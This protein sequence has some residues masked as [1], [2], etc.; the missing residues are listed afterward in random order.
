M[1]ENTEF[2]LSRDCEA[3]Q[4]PSGQTT[5][6]PAGTQGVIT[7]SLGGS[8]TI[9]TYQGLA[10]IAERDLDALGLEKS[11]AQPTQKPA[12]TVNGEVSEEDVW[13]QLRQ[14][15][16]PEIPV[17]IVDL[18]LVYDCR[19]IKKDGGGT[20]VEV[21]M[22]LT[23]PG[24]GMGPAIAHDAQSKILSIDGVDEADVQL[25]WDPPWNQNMISEAGRMKLGM[26][27]GR[28]L[29]VILNEA[30]NLWSSGRATPQG[31]P[32]MFRFAQHDRQNNDD[33][34][35]VTFL[36]LALT[37][38]AW[39]LDSSPPERFRLKNS[40]RVL[41]ID[42]PLTKIILTENIPGL[43]AEADVVK[44]RRGYARNYLL[45]RGKAYEVT[46]GALRQLDEL[47]QKRAEREAR[48]LNEAEELARRIGKARF[49]FTLETGETGKA[50]GS[51]TAQDIMNRVKNE[52]GAEID[53]HKII[54]ERP[55]KDTGEHEV[56]IK[57]HHDVTAQ[58]VFQVKSAEEPKAEAEG[59][60]TEEPEKKKKH[61][62]FHR[63]KD[64]KKETE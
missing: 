14:C 55:I 17:N 62:F 9:A 34:F 49:I 57:L 64:E 33:I 13:N 43:G 24:C 28:T 39:I 44:V 22:T 10:R 23:A 63:K 20:R 2:T 52:L 6:I 5:T 15:Y 40:E 51:V 30:K 38:R 18:G 42:M 4:I 7:Q 61:R 46:P 21:K 48:E 1:Y 50:F 26:I 11:Q 54:L 27:W 45:P 31:P 41:E 60:A 16:D 12:G 8:Y 29:P 59:A 37:M 32:E 25:V 53:R 35:F 56:A 3:I 58:L 47:K 36:I 19:L